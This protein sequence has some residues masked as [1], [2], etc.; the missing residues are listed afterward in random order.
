MIAYEASLE[1]AKNSFKSL[2]S[3]REVIFAGVTGI[4]EFGKDIDVGAI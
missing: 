3:L 1:S 2:V 4:L